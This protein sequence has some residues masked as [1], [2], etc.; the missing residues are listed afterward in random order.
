MKIICFFDLPSTTGYEKKEY[1]L[2]RKTL[3]ENGFTMVQYSVYMRT[4]PNR[5]YSKKF[6]S[7]LCE[8]A[9]TDGN[10]SL[11]TVTEKQYDDMVFIL[12]NKS[13][14]EEVIA[15]NKMVVI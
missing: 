5:E 13:H 10:I 8:V 1:R 3:L 15:N 4:C 7:K 2:F 9:P 11:L 6:K 12:G 14:Q